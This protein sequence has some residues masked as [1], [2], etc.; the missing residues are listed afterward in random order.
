MDLGVV[1]CT[2]KAGVV[3][4]VHLTSSMLLRNSVAGPIDID[5]VLNGAKQAAASSS[6]DKDRPLSQ[7]RLYAVTYLR[8]DYNYSS[9]FHFFSMITGNFCMQDVFSNKNCTLCLG[10]GSLR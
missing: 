3:H 10:Y 8:Y 9:N 5:G 4:L 2:G 7:L 1:S 6:K